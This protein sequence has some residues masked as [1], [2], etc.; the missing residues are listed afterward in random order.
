[1]ARGALDA[2]ACGAGA[3]TGDAA[4]QAV[5]ARWLSEK[6]GWLLTPHPKTASKQ[7]TGQQRK[8]QMPVLIQI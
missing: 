7:E 3:A 1:M 2:P 4:P 5:A 6:E 8:A